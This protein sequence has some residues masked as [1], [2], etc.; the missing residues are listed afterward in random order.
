MEWRAIESR[1]G[2]M[3]THREP[4]SAPTESDENLA[5]WE[6]GVQRM[7]A[8][9]QSRFPELFDESGEL[10][11]ERAMELFRRGTNGKRTFT[12]AEFIALTEGGASRRADAS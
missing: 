8:D 12:R 9:L 2:D 3:S 5:A 4:Q 6:A 1:Q 10:I 11:M 7:K